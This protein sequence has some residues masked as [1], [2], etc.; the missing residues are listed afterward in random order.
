MS[1]SR[2][3]FLEGQDIFKSDENFLKEFSKGFYRKIIDTN[4]F[5]TFEN[6]LRKWIINLDKDVESI[7]ELMQNHEQ[8]KLWFSSAIGF[9]YQLGISCDVDRNKAL[10]LYLLVVGNNEKEFLNRN[11]T[12]LYLLEENH[13]EFDMLRSINIVIGKYL[14]SSF[15]YKDIILTRKFEVY[16][17]FSC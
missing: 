12:H 17:E 6:I 8:A 15:Y 14:L 3:N 16:L 13:N 4:D 11:F 2:S 9:F 10:E 1:N 5:S 7:F